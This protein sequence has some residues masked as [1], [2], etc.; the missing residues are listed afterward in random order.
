MP[1]ISLLI[2]LTPFAAGLYV[3]AKPNRRIQLITFHSSY[4]LYTYT[5]YTFILHTLPG[6][7]PGKQ[8]EQ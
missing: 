2:G 6:H 8:P 1:P 4:F 3:V 5:S 7:K